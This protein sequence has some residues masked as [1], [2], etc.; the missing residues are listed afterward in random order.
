MLS[1]NQIYLGDCLEVMKEIDDKSIDLI[2]CDLPYGTT[3]CKWD[4][5]IPFNK[6]WI[7]YERIV[8]DNKAIILFGRNPFFAY[9]IC[10]NYKLFRYEIIW[11]KNAATD[12]A[13]SSNKPIT[14]C[15][16]TYTYNAFEV[17]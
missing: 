11:D 1:V 6:L 13:Q 5:V 4:V 14:A 7:E 2:L 9:L 12:F 17:N 3:A 8:R 10:S 16:I 15:L